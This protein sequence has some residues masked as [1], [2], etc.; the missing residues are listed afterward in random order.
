MI[1]IIIPIVFGLIGA[2]VASGKG[3][4]P[5]AWFVICAVLPLVGLIILAYQSSENGTPPAPFVRSDFDER[6]ENMAKFDPEV[7]AAIGRLQPLGDLALDAFRIVFS[8]VRDKAAI[9]SIVGEIE[10]ASIEERLKMVGLTHV[11]TSSGIPIF[12]HR[13]GN[14]V[15]G[16]VT[17]QSLE[18]ARGVAERTAK[19]LEK[20]R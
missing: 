6:W 11:E 12:K 9:P 17:S 14:Y 5:I 16:H 15:V 8:D 13:N 20:T 18:V 1:F 3:R 10:N 7:R 4:S 19:E 2:A